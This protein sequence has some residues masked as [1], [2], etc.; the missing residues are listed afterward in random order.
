VGDSAYG[1]TGADYLNGGSGNDTLD[2]GGGRDIFGFDH[3]SGKDTVQY[4]RPG[5]DQLDLRAWR[6]ASFEDI[7]MAQRTGYTVV[8]LAGT[9]HYVKL[10]NVEKTALTAADFIL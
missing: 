6:F 2:G 5:E 10:D 3:G 1:G 9:S 8:Y 7:A 4:F